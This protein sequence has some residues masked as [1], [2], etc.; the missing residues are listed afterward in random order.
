[1]KKAKGEFFFEY[2]AVIESIDKS[3]RKVIKRVTIHNLIVNDGLNL[4]RNWMHGDA[5]NNPTAIAIG[6]DA[7]AAQNTDTALLAEVLRSAATIS[8]PANYQVKYVKVFS[9]GS[10]VSHAV[11]E[12]GVFDSAV[13]SGSTMLARLI[14]DNTLDADT[15]LSVTITYTIARA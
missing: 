9:V 11:K 15:D 3:T 14:C 2:N 13:V 5:V 6:T 10:G 4:I 12:V 8:K 1:M 7:T